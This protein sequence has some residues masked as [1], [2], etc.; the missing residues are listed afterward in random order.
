MRPGDVLLYEPEE[1]RYVLDRY[2]PSM[3]ARPLD[4]VLPTRSQASHV[5]VLTSFADQPRYRQVIDRQI[6]ALR[7][8]RQLEDRQSLPGVSLWRFR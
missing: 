5:E 8:T 1:L 6:G 2:A 4:G 7:A 3:T